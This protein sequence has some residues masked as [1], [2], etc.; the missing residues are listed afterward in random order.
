MQEQNQVDSTLAEMASDRSVK[1]GNRIPA[2]RPRGKRHLS[3]PIQ[4]VRVRA[5][6]RRSLY[7]LRAGPAPAFT[8]W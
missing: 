5:G 8:L 3:S 4:P 7:A 2:G 6:E 1:L